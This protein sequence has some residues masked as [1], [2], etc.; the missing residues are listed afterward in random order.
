MAGV[1]GELNFLILITL[2]VNLNSHTWL[3]ATILDSAVLNLNLPNY[4]MG[5]MVES[6]LLGS[7]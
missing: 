7:L 2:T 5:I 4:E 1:T 3:L 6:S